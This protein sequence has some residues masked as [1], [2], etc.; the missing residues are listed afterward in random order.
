MDKIAVAVIGAGF[1]ADYHARAILQQ[2]DI[3]MKVVCDRT[4]EAAQRFAAKYGI[5]ETASD[6]SD[7]LSREDI[8]AAILCTPNKFHAPQAMA[9]LKRGKDV[10]I[11]KPMA[12]NPAEGRE[13]AA[14]ARENKRLVMVGH[15]WRF[16]AE[17]DYTKELVAAGKIGRIVKTKGYGI[18]EN[19][20]PSGWF[21]K[22]ELAG[23]GA[24]PDMGVHA[25]DTVRY[26]LGDPRPKQVYARIGTFYGDYDVD[27]TAVVVISWDNGTTSI[28]ESGWWHPH[29]DGPEAAT[30]LFGTAGYASIFPTKF[31]T[32]RGDSCE[33]FTPTMPEREEH[34]C[35][36]M[37]NRQ[38][39][40]FADCI[41]NRNEPAVGTGQGQIV[42]EIVA[43]AYESAKTRQAVML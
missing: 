10:F 18:H 43:A 13:I 23:G 33:E 42:L 20:G 17:V 32:K 36:A 30:R 16:D 5:K 26:I 22:K 39:Q 11:E 37:Y 40:H 41:R 9:F 25:V 31:K 14:A 6:V 12:M 29:A 15:M 24:L 28:V 38:M 1:I 3:E 21:T 19:W 7:V 2:R 27:D 4:T 34:C 35:Q 8:D